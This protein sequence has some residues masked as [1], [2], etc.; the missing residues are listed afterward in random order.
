MRMTFEHLCTL[1]TVG[2]FL[3]YFTLFYYYYLNLLALGCYIVLFSV[4]L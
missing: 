2:A 3:Y 1:Q 4:L